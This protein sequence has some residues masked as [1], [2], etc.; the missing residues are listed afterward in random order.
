M[1][2]R[3]C[4]AYKIIHLSLIIP[5]HNILFH[6]DISRYV[7]Y[8]IHDKIFL[9]SI[10]VYRARALLIGHLSLRIIYILFFYITQNLAV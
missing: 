8:W 2:R 4:E 7:I 5:N 6:Y 3:Q 1:D 10:Y 9:K